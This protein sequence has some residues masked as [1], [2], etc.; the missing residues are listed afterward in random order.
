[1]ALA[2]GA[3]GTRAPVEVSLAAAARVALA[4]EQA[5]SKV[6]GMPGLPT[7][8]VVVV[9]VVDIS[10]KVQKQTLPMP[11]ARAALELSSSAT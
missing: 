5:A 2:A 11:A 4:Q 7:V 1:M 6:L 3:L 9:V 8:P 10:M